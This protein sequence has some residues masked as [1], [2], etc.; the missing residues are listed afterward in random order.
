MLGDSEREVEG[1]AKSRRH[2][3]IARFYLKNFTEPMFGNNLFV[4]ESKTQKWE[5]RTP[6]GVGWFPN[7]YYM[8]DNSGEKTDAF[9]KFLNEYIETP[10]T[11][12][13]RKAATEPDTL[14]IKERES[15][16]MFIGVTTARTPSAM[17]DITNRFFSG[18]PANDIGEVE[19]NTRLW[20]SV[21]NR[22]YTAKSKEE[23][24]KPSVFGAILV[25]AASLRTRI[26]QWNWTFIRTNR[27]C[28][29]ITSDSP[30]L[31]QKTEN[32]IRIVTFP[33]SSEIA[34]VISNMELRANRD[35]MQ[36]VAAMNRGTLENAKE[37]VICCKK[38][39]P[40]DSFL[41]Q[42]PKQ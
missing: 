5:P 27:D 26:I 36:D 33:I 28:P 25:W 37:F 29:F 31:L 30:A 1:M 16:A 40:C 19:K 35:S 18:L 2:H 42:W 24:L 41:S 8:F 22:N 14:T 20:C 6:N 38:N 9:E 39:F 11:P 23:F 15:I 4:Y 34:V 7:L 3:Y 12:I 21:T 13:M 10:L 32:N 17:K